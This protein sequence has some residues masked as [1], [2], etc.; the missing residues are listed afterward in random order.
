MNLELL[1]KGFAN[2]SFS[3]IDLRLYKLPI[4]IKLID[5]LNTF[6]SH[7]KAASTRSNF[8]SYQAKIGKGFYAGVQMKTVRLIEI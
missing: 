6:N 5:S 1:E 7:F 8:A 4:T 2:R 3:Y